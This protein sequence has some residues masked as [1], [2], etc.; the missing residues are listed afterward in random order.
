MKNSILLFGDYWSDD[1]DMSNENEC[2]ITH[3]EKE[4]FLGLS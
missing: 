1:A 4:R 3:T 2:L